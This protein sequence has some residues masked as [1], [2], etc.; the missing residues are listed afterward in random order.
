MV[1]A[2]IVGNVIKG[3]LNGTEVITATD[4]TYTTGNPGMGFNY[5]V[6]KTNAD[7]GF[8]SYEVDSNND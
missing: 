1:E 4:K 3:F 5:G 8:S 7:F 6:G 2:S